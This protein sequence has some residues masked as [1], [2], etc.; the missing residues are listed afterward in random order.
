MKVVTL[1]K[2][3]V[4]DITPAPAGPAGGTARTVNVGDALL[5]TP[6][7]RVSLSQRCVYLSF[8]QWALGQTVL[9]GYDG[10]SGSDGASRIINDANQTF[11]IAGFSLEGGIPL[12]RLFVGNG[13][14][15]NSIKV[16]VVAIFAVPTFD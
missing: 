4:L 10:I 7:D 9:V 6:L 11:E 2:S 15:A 8:Q 12:Q 3:A 1:G 5:G 16:R 13:D 14:Q